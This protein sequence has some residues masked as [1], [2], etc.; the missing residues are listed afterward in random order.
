MTKRKDDESTFDV[1]LHMTSIEGWEEFKESGYWLDLRQW[2]EDR[3]DVLYKSLSV[4]EDE[5]EIRM[6]QG[7][8][9]QHVDLINAPDLIMSHLEAETKNNEVDN[10]QT[11]EDD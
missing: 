8:I 6:M 2:L 11:T 4:E 5:K 3:L 10:E 1:G 7:A 9:K